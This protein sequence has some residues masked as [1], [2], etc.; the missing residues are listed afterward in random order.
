[1]RYAAN[2]P[3]RKQTLVRLMDYYPAMLADLGVDV[4]NGTR[5][6]A[7]TVAQFAPDAVV[8]ATGSAPRRDGFQV[9]HNYLSSKA[10]ECA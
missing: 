3:R 5:A 10:G 8:L 7:A 2:S 1:M 4:R 6:T 9:L